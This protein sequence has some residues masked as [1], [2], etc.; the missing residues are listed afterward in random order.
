[1]EELLTVRFTRVID[2][3]SRRFVGGERQARQVHRLPLVGS[4]RHGGKGQG[5]TDIEGRVTGA[6][7]SCLRIAGGGGG[8]ELTDGRVAV[9]AE[10][11]E[12]RHLA[13]SGAPRY[14]RRPTSAVR[15]V[16]VSVAVDDLGERS[17]MELSGIELGEWSSTG[18]S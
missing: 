15:A 11:T 17:P 7:M 1:M 14:R 8:G 4:R 6:L 10:L 12:G 13:G 9:G 18:S 2:G 16:R 5:V 3:A